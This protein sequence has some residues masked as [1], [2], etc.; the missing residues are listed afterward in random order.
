MNVANQAGN[1]LD[2]RFG[3]DEIAIRHPRCKASQL[4]TTAKTDFKIAI[5]LAAK[6]IINRPRRIKG[7]L[8]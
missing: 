5:G 2:E 7:K 4:L 6:L 1:T 3:T 8:W